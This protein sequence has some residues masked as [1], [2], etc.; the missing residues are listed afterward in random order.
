ML[1]DEVLTVAGLGS[2]TARVGVKPTA[3]MGSGQV[4]ARQLAR[5]GTSALVAPKGQ[6]EQA[7][8][9]G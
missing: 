5:G 4:M 2:G 9:A 1:A 8:A 7:G 3:V 6:A